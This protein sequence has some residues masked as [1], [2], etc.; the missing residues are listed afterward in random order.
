[1]SDNDVTKQLMAEIAVTRED[2]ARAKQY[3]LKSKHS[4]TSAIVEDWLSEQKF[5]VGATVNL[6]DPNRSG[7]VSLLA[8]SYSLRMALYMAVWELV[9]ANEL[10]PAGPPERWD[11]SVSYKHSRGAGPIDTP[12]LSC[13][14]L[15]G[16]HRPPPVACMPTDPDIFLE[17]VDCS[18]CSV[19]S[20]GRLRLSN[21][22]P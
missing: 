3:V 7:F 14:F 1:M 6:D 2:I 18:T 8:R 10:L 16:F 22:V 17:G 9:T 15:G 5:N 11:A 13:T 12:G 4:R 21:H 20:F 19:E